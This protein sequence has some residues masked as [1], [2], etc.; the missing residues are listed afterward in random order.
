MKKQKWTNFNDAEDQM[1][2]ELI[3][4]KTIVKVVIN[5]KRGGYITEEWNDGYATKSN[6]SNSVYLACEFVVIGGEYDN[7]KVWSNI[8]LYSEASDKYATIGRSTIKAI[9]E[10]A[11]NLHPKDTSPQAAAVRSIKDFGDLNNLTLVAEIIINDKGQSPRNEIKTIITPSHPK[12]EEYMDVKSGK[13]KID[14]KGGAANQK[15]AEVY[16]DELPF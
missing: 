15:T 11:N 14:Y 16:D 9:L 6:S 8:G 2:Y 3:P 4:H 7:R 13:Y 1:S 12:Y 5:V 10:S